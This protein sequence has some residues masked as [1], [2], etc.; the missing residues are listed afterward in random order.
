MS[1]QHIVLSCDWERFLLKRRIL[2]HKEIVPNQKQPLA[3]RAIRR[4][5]FANPPQSKRA[6]FPIAR[7][8][9][10]L[11]F[12]IFIIPPLKVVDIRPVDPAWRRQHRMRYVKMCNHP[13]NGLTARE[14][15]KAFNLRR[16]RS[17]PHSL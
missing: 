12:V 8:F 3:S 13:T 10:V 17:D 11:P 6:H 9:K 1:A 5:D 7:S 4:Q 14:T 2:R 16:M 15:Q